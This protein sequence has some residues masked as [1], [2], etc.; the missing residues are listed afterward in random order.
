MR[1][2]DL[3]RYL[4]VYYK[5]AE[6]AEKIIINCALT[7][8]AA[9]AVG[10]FVPALSLPAMIISCFG[11]VWMMYA[12]LC[13]CLGIPFQE[14]ILKTL[15][16]AALSNIATNLI[17]VFV[18][19]LLTAFIPG[20]GSVS[21]AAVTFACV[22]LAGLMF[23]KMLLAFARMGKTGDA[24]GSMTPGNASSYM[25]QCGV[26]KDDVKNAKDAFNQNFPK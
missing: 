18:V 5:G 15:A 16:S 13:D 23:M 11:A 17:A 14:N 21:G 8:A 26:S 25:K 20:I 6:E 7:A 9:A 24:L 22:Y 19:E 12:Q 10:G 3:L 1:M 2:S 4:E